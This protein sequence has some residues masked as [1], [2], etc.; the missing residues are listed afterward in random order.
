MRER[1]RQ[2]P[3]GVRRRGQACR[4]EQFRTACPQSRRGTHARRGESRQGAHLQSAGGD[5]PHRRRTQIRRSADGRVP[6]AHRPF[7]QTQGR[8]IR[9]LRRDFRRVRGKEP[10]AG[11]PFQGHRG[12]RERHRHQE[13][14][15][16]RRLETPRRAQGQSVRDSR[17]KSHQRRARQESAGDA[18][19]QKGESGRRGDLSFHL[20]HQREK[21]KGGDARAFAE[22][23]RNA[24]RKAGGAGSDKRAGSRRHDAQFQA[25]AC[26]RSA[27]TAGVGQGRLSGLSGGGQTAHARRAA[28]SGAE[29][30]DHGRACRGH[31]RAGGLRVRNRVR[32]RSGA[33]ERAGGERTRRGGAHH[34]PQTEELRQSDIPSAQRV[35]SEVAGTGIHAR[36]QRAG[37]L[38]SC[39]RTRRMRRQV[40]S[41]RAD[42]A[43]HDRRR[44]RHG[45]GGAAVQEIQPGIQD[46][47]A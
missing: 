35:P 20:R 3:Q 29:E 38:R 1:L 39:V 25:G 44:G 16:R 11:V 6:R 22:E 14:R 12:A 18:V 19:R 33:A 8:G 21:R 2:V 40:L 41:L 34:I 30:Q 36:A 46:R 37:V 28:R 32:A 15:V 4:G 27:Q 23:Q 5:Q 43:G 9:R 45:Y 24:L 17:R 47:Y 31:Q 13:R 7:R 26:G 10:Q 42:A